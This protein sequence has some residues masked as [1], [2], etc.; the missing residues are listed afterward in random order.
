[1]QDM[2]SDLNK[3]HDEARTTNN[4]LAHLLSVVAE[5]L[6]RTRE[7]LRRIDLGKDRGIAG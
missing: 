1:M 7:L 2:P 3:L 5:R 6:S 4:I